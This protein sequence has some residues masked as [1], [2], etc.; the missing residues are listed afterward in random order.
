MRIN[1]RTFQTTLLLAIGGASLASLSAANEAPAA[2]FYRHRLRLQIKGSEVEYWLR[3][4]GPGTATADVPFVLTVSLN[5]DGSNVVRR[6]THVSLAAA[7]HIMRG[8]FSLNDTAWKVG[9]PLFG[10]V[11]FADGK[12]TT[13]VRQMKAL[14]SVTPA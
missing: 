13:K 14:P 10:S 12:A 3:V 4:A 7:S 6:I 2:V 1:R 8:K 5:P 9:A 11:A